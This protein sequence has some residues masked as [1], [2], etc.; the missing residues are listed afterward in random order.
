MLRNCFVFSEEKTKLN[1]WAPRRRSPSPKDRVSKRFSRFSNDK[2][3]NFDPKITINTSFSSAVTSQN[4]DAQNK[5]QPISVA[6]HEVTGQP[7]LKNMLAR[8]AVTFPEIIHQPTETVQTVI[9]SPP[10]LLDV[11]PPQIVQGQINN[12]LVLTPASTQNVLVSTPL[13][14]ILT[15]VNLQPTLVTTNVNQQNNIQQALAVPPPCLPAIELAS[16]PPPNPIQLQNIPPPEPL[17]TLNIPQPAPIQ[18]QNI[19]TP[20]QI[21][22]NEI[23]N[24]K[25]LDLLTIPTPNED[26]GLSDPDFLKNIPPPN[27]AIPP[28]Q[29]Q[30]NSVSLM[31][32]AQ[33]IST[34]ITV[35]SNQNVLVHNIPPPQLQTMQNVQAATTNNVL[36][37]APNYSA[38][39]VA[40]PVGVVQVSSAPTTIPSLMAQPILPPPGISL[41]VNLNCPPPILSGNGLHQ[42]P[43]GF[44]SQATGLG[45]HI[46][47]MRIPPP[48][49][50][51]CINSVV[52][53][54]G[55]KSMNSG[56]FLFHIFIYLW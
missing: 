36:Q 30:D 31:S 48:S 42:Q 18:V 55:F 1:R 37:N 39:T 28:P 35:P 21:Q 14:P 29:L 3:I 45:Q 2:V 47:P 17:N 43:S 46:P 50:M 16:I 10:V 32:A 9:T 56:K 33:A 6:P 49:N 27:K 7:L 52:S 54:Q 25:P 41:N 53:L 23:P 26:N 40:V 19:P 8:Q 4:F 13:Q 44:V 20:N 15:T 38:V 11:P 22:L 34:T 51:Q 5:V 24:P 12:A